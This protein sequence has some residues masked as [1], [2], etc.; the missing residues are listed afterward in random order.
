MNGIEQLLI[1]TNIIISYLAGEPLVT[2]F[3]RRYRAGLHLSVI[4]KMEVLSY[5][6][7]G[8]DDCRNGA[9]TSSDLSHEEYG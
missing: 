1:D 2:A 3:L 8:C 7:A 5:P 4:T 9:G 6:S